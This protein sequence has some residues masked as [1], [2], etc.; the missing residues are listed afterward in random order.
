MKLSATDLERLRFAHQGWNTLY[1][2]NINRLNDTY[3]KI[4]GLL[5][6][7]ITSL[8]DKDVLQY[9][10]GISKWENVSSGF[11]TTTTTTT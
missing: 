2:A 9:N 10:S 8:T 6:V 5:D 1:N 4:S 11:L 3:L 7:S